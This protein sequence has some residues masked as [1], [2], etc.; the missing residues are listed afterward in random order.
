MKKTKKAIFLALLFTLVLILG[1]CSKTA[2]NEHLPE[3]CQTYSGFASTASRDLYELLAEAG[4]PINRGNYLTVI[5]LI[6]LEFEVDD[7]YREIDLGGIQCFQNLTSLKLR[8]RSFK[9]LSEISALS[10]IQSIEL[11]GTNVVSIDSFKNLS[12]IKSLV[13]S[14]TMNLQSVEGVEEMTKLTNLDLSNNGIVN[15]EGL[16]NLIN[17]TTLY[18]NDNEIISFPSINQLEDLE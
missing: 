14:E 9:D 16:N 6:S 11:I 10:N 7:P 18:L 17:L 12:K 1:S 8:G 3:Y 15:I 5:S 13:I 2:E 4:E